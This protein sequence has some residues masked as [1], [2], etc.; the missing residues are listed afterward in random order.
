[1]Y[2]PTAAAAFRDR[3]LL[4]KEKITNNSPRVAITSERK[5][6]PEARWCVERLTAGVENMRLASTAPP[7]QPATWVGMYA[8]AA[9]QRTPPRA[10]STSDT[11]GLR[12]APEIGPNIKMMA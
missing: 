6:A 5:W 1:M 8:A 4:A 11:T 10:A 7:M 2:P 12:W 9:V 3:P